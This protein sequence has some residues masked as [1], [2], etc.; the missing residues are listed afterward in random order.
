MSCVRH[1][2]SMT[3]E[4]ELNRRARQTS[5]EAAYQKI[6]RVHICRLAPRGTPQREIIAYRFL[7]E[8]TR[9]IHRLFPSSKAIGVWATSCHP[10]S[11]RRT[12]CR[13]NIALKHN[14][15]RHAREAGDKY[16]PAGHS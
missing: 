13:A 12:S 2:L 3:H 9:R 6:P 8:T 1:R 15:A 16:F 4:V 14:E 5:T 7:I 11:C 10:T